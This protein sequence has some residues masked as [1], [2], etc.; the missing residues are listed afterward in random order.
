M[1]QVINA[2]NKELT[3]NATISENT[4]LVVD[5][6]KVSVIY[7]AAILEQKGY[8]VQAAHNAS[9]GLA[10][11]A[12]QQFGVVISDY[13]MPEMDG[14]LFLERVRWNYPDMV[15][16]MLSG[17]GN[18]DCFDASINRAAIYQFLTKPIAADSL[19]TTVQQAFRWRR[20]GLF[21][22]S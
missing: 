15:R 3:A 7:V 8:S 13:Q 11:L 21:P 2:S 16:I 4:V 18:L 17:E 20:T 9:E 19:C 1:G 5:D 6:D 10:L 22:T 14:S 12:H